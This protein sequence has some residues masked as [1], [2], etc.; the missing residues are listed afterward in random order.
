M[1]TEAA[2]TEVRTPNPQ[3]PPVEG[4][5][6]AAEGPRSEKK[7]PTPCPRGRGKQTPSGAWQERRGDFGNQTPSGL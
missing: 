2:F 7:Q 3:I 6:R 4:T 5:A 1:E